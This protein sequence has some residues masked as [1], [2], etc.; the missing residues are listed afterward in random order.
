M[1]YLA[2]YRA[3]I[4]TLFHAVA[5][6]HIQFSDFSRDIRADLDLHFRIN[7]AARSYRFDDR[8]VIGFLCQKPLVPSSF[9][10][11]NLAIY[12]PAINYCHYNQYPLNCL[13]HLILILVLCRIIEIL[14]SYFSVRY[15]GVAFSC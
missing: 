8:P 12:K 11:T 5:F 10:P 2:K 4:K 3:N 15:T 9:P 13:I 14:F 1:R 7:I 6:V